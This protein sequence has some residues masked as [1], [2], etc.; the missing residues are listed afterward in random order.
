MKTREVIPSIAWIVI[1]GLICNA[2]KS[3]KLG[4]LRH[5]EPG[6]FPFCIGCTLILLAFLQLIKLL[7]SGKDE[8]EI[9]E[10][11]P[12]SG[13]LKRLVSVFVLL[14]FYTM[15]LKHL[16]F[17]S[18]TFVFFVALFKTLAQK[19]WQYSI[20]TSLAVSALSY[21]FFEFWL[22]VNLPKGPFSW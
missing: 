17:I 2:A 5:P 10:F 4:S 9:F 20:L 11:W 1:G 6:M 16:G 19:S 3:L 8:S 21:I 22:Q 13:A 12:H 7:F 18:C 14:I 15:A